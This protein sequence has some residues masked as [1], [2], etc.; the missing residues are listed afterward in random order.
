MFYFI[1]HVKLL[2]D[3]TPKKSI[4]II[5]FFFFRIIILILVYAFILLLV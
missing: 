1:L 3:I 5:M 4:D 2:L